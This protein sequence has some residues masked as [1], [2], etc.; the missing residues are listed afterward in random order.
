MVEEGAREG[1]E[2]GVMRRRVRKYWVKWGKASSYGMREAGL[3]G[4][5][6]KPADAKGAEAGLV[7]GFTARVNRLRKKA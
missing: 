2:A 5:H 4:F 1:Y 3:S 6:Q 7:K